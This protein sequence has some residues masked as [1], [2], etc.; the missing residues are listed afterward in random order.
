MFCFHFLRI[1]LGGCVNFKSDTSAGCL[2]KWYFVEKLI[3]IANVGAV[4]DICYNMGTEIFKIEEEM[5]E[6]MRPKVGN[7]PL[8][9]R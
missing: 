8:K 2:K 1:F 5:T 6:K 4:L 7:P 9:N 3:Q